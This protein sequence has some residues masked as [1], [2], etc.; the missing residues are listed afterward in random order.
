MPEIDVDSYGRFTITP[1]AGKQLVMTCSE[2]GKL[3]IVADAGAIPAGVERHNVEITASGEMASGSGLVGLNI[4]LTPIGTAGA[5]ASAIY[6]KVVQGTT[7]RVNG[8]IS[9]VEIEV[10][11]TNTNPSDWFPL[12]LNANSVANGQHSAYI[13]LRTYGSLAL[14]QFLWIE[15]QTIGADN[16]VTSLVAANNPTAAT[17]TLRIMIDDT[18]YY[19]MLCSAAAL[20]S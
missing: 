3:N 13:A 17:H 19:I 16:D 7:K 12:V 2:G 15:D 6:A 9:G 8:Y 5:W 4:A 18:A 1:P 11:N 10:V 14:N 20:G